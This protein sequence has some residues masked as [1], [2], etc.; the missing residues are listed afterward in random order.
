MVNT[1]AAN[2]K[3]SKRSNIPPCPGSTFPLSFTSAF[4]LRELSKRSPIVPKIEIAIPKI[5]EI[6]TI[7]MEFAFFFIEVYNQNPIPAI[8]NNLKIVKNNLPSRKK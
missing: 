4:L 1:T 6:A 8:A 5:K 2:K 3:A 7:K